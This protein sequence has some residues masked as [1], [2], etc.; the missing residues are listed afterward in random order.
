[1]LVAG[2]AW[3]TFGVLELA[4]GV[5]GLI[6]ASP[7]EPSGASDTVSGQLGDGVQAG[8]STGFSLTSLIPTVVGA[9]L[10]ILA[11]LLVARRSW[12]RLGLELTGTV[13]VIEL[14]LRGQTT[15]F[16][17]M[18]LLLL[19][20]IPTMSAVTHRYLY[21]DRTPVDEPDTR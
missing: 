4:L 17:A 15:A 13:A 7:S 1:M 16:A 8:P 12:A 21:G 14:A 6:A 19:A 2:S 3:L 5:G 18:A 20:T 11:I 9:V 10:I